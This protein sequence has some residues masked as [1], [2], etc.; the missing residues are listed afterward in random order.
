MQVMQLPNRFEALGPQDM[1]DD[2]TLDW[3]DEGRIV[4]F[5]IRNTNQKAVDR[6]FDVASQVF[7][8]FPEDEPLI[9]MH[10]VRQAGLGTYMR[11]KSAALTEKGARFTRGRY[12][13]LISESAVSQIV[14][15]FLNVQS[16]RLTSRER[17]AFTDYDAALA[18]LREDAS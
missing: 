9:V 12:A 6:W 4:I 5:S 2:V 14:R 1:G 13:V 7:E 11:A 16:R 3:L 17:R 15:L 10:D 18:W 8:T